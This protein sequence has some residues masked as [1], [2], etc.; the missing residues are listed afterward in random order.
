MILSF[1]T[2]TI[3]FLNIQTPKTFVVITRKFELRGSTIVMCP[4]GA[5]RIVSDC[6]FD[7][8]PVNY[9]DPEKQTA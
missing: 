7:V 1:W 2:D 6:C 3:N 8:S 5:D 4:N 9:P